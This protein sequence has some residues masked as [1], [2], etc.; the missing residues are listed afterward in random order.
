MAALA[1]NNRQWSISKAQRPH[2]TRQSHHL[3]TNQLMAISCLPI[4]SLRSP[5]RHPLNH[6]SPIFS[7]RTSNTPSISKS[8]A[9]TLTCP[10]L[11]LQQTAAAV[12]TA[13]IAISDTLTLTPLT[14]PSTNSS[15]SCISNCT[16]ITSRSTRTTTPIKT[17]LETTIP[18]CHPSNSLTMLPPVVP[19]VSVLR[20]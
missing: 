16:I 19:A 17:E 6:S 10:T 15:I 9:I 20:T 13:A 3:F 8:N 11:T 12:A 18:A 2:T 1:P 14:T 7:N 4:N 5:P